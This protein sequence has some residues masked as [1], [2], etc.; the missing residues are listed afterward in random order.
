[1]ESISPEEALY[2]G[3]ELSWNFKFDLAKIIFQRFLR[4]S[5]DTKFFD[6]RIKLHKLELKIFQV[7]ITGKKSLIDKCMVKLLKLEE[8]L[9]QV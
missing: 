6:F 8:K 4:S 7:I 5:E 3:I 1:M 9:M 2:Q